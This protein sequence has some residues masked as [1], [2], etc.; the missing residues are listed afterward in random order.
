[1]KESDNKN[2]I[3]RIASLKGFDGVLLG[4]D[5]DGLF[6]NGHVY[7][8]REIM[9]EIILTDLGEHAIKDGHDIIYTDINGCAQNGAH[10][11]TKEEYKQ[12]IKKWYNIK[13]DFVKKYFT[14]FDE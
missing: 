2:Q 1:M 10:C 14:S 4:R 11:V 7:A 5:F 12:I 8:V 3:C 6:K 9:G 13:F